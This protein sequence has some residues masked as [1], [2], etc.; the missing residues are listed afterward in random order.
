MTSSLGKKEKENF[1][2]YLE[3]KNLYSLRRFVS[4]RLGEEG[5]NFTLGTS[6][7]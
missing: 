5:G 4:G 1:D 2:V 7:I 3:R 6:R